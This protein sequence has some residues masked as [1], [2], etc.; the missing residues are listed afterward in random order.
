M[1]ALSY[2]V[3][4]YDSA[5]CCSSMSIFGHRTFLLSNLTQPI[6]PGNLRRR[7]PGAMHW[8][9]GKVVTTLTTDEDDDDNDNTVQISI[10]T[11]DRRCHKHWHQHLMYN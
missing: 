2:W 8:M 1:A 9:W 10:T 7:P 5:I 11:A 4:R 6:S 3:R